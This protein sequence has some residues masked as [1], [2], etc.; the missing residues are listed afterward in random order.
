MPSSSQIVQ[1]GV[2]Q[3][4]G[5]VREQRG[6]QRQLG[7]VD[8]PHRAEVEDER[9]VG[10]PERALLG[11]E[12]RLDQRVV[13]R[14]GEDRLR[15]RRTRVSTLIVPRCLRH[16]TRRR[17]GAPGVE[18]AGLP[19][20]AVGVAG[21]ASA[22]S[23][24]R[25]EKPNRSS[26]TWPGSVG[27]RHIR[28][29]GRSVVGRIRSKS[30]RVPPG[31]SRRSYQSSW[32]QSPRVA[33]QVHGERRALDDDLRL[34]DPGLDRLQVRAQRHRRAVRDGQAAHARSRSTS[35]AS[36]WAGKV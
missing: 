3:L 26:T 7:A 14:G 29:N 31:I 6:D 22:C 30:S 24:P 2:R 11:R 1:Q 20:A 5:A 19:D 12:A 17:L 35:R 15:A 33:L 9:A 13:E 8:V 27:P 18:R 10:R 32:R 34:G 23:T 25:S 36:R 28:P 4:D 21:C 16:A